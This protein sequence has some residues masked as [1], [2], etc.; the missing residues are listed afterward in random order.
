MG[1]DVVLLQNV[2]APYRLPVFNCLATKVTRLDVLVSAESERRRS[3]SIDE[4]AMDF[5]LS[6]LRGLMIPVSYVREVPVS[7]GLPSM[8]KRLKPDVIVCSGF[9]LQTVQALIWRRV[10][11]SAVVIWT[12]A[13]LHEKRAIRQR[14]VPSVDA[15]ISAGSES[16]G[17]LL[18][19]GARASSIFTAYN[20]VDMLVFF[21]RKSER[22]WSSPSFAFVGSLVEGKGLWTL[23]EASKLLHRDGVNHRIEV[24]G[25][26]PLRDALEAEVVRHRLPWVFRGAQDAWEIAEVYRSAVA[27]VLPSIL[28]RNPLVLVE[29]LCC[30]TPV[31]AADG[32][33]SARDHL[34]DL[35]HGRVFR[36]GAALELAEAMNAYTTRPLSHMM[37]SRLAAESAERFS[38]SAAAC[39]MYDAVRF[40]ADQ[41]AQDVVRSRPW[42]KSDDL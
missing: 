14:M 15:F 8:L 33:G 16:R 6:R 3:W 22:S 25:E 2:L 21:H 4:S 19:M 10:S 26:G 17:R 37:R 39:A 18:D 31:I 7:W 29:S 11:Q 13:H 35:Q 42:T 38:P 36:T 34:V 9:S 41:R 27:C 28:D 23:M 12:E 40:A 5:Q 30:G 24:V 32:V 1:L 20:S